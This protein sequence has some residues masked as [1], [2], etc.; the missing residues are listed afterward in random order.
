M[1]ALLDLRSIEENAQV[2]IIL[3]KKT[4]VSVLSV[5]VQH[6]YMSNSFES[7]Y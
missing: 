2:V 1:L 4:L 3:L 6:W 7:K 5:L